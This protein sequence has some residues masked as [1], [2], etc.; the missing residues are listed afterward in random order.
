MRHACP[1]AGACGGMYTANTM[2]SAIEALGHVAAVQR[3]DPRR[4]SRQDR[5]VPA[6]RRRGAQPARARPASR[7]TIMTREAFE[8]AIAVVCA[9]GGSTNAVLHLIAMARAA[10][11]PLDDRRLPGDLRSRAAARRSEAERPLRD[12]GPAPRRRHARGDEAAA[13][14]GRAARRLHDGHRQDARRESRG[15][16]GP[17]GRAGR[18]PAVGRSDQGDGAHPDPARLARAGRLRSRRSPARKGSASRARRRSSTAKK[19]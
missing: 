15:A 10:G 19:T 12:G 1:G 18:D 17:R 8:N 16:A 4:G 2:A 6:R 5:R 7:A 13:R 9:L 11:V 14:E 3:V